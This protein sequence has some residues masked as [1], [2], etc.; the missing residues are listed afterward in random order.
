MSTGQTSILLADIGGTHARFAVCTTQD[1][2][3]H[4]A[5]VLKISDHPTI[6]GAIDTYISTLDHRPERAALAVAAPILADEV[7]FTNS[8]WEFTRKQLLS[9]FN[10]QRL[11][12]FN[13]FQ[14]L[15]LTLPHLKESELYPLGR[16]QQIPNRTLAVIGPGTGLGVA[17]LVPG[18]AGWIPVSGEGGHV[19]L[20]ARTEREQQILTQARTLDE[21][22]S[23]EDLI[24]GPGL[25]ALYSALSALNGHAPQFDDPARICAAARKRLEPTAVESLE[26]FYLF[27]AS[28]AANL[29]LTVGALGGVYLAGG[30]ISKNIDLLHQSDFR[31]R[32]NSH[33]RYSEYLARIPCFAITSDLSAMTGLAHWACDQLN[34]LNPC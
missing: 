13:D 23:A 10:W 18:E 31:Q 1:Q 11:D 5:Q 19:T 15:A 4:Y 7:N 28:T 27:L 17:S 12:L 20:S 29:A 33:G 16:K 9:Q 24:S 34:E 26:H 22:I 30:M 8:P 6:Y 21:H 14:A 3:I 25:V 32:F 2:S